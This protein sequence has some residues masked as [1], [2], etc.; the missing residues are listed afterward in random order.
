MARSIASWRRAV[1]L[2]WEKWRRADSWDRMVKYC[3]EKVEIYFGRKFGVLM[4]FIFSP[5]FTF[6]KL[7]LAYFYNF[8]L[9][10]SDS[11]FDLHET[12]RF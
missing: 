8:K 1:S 3:D 4:F 9:T 5:F 11:N 10:H 2:H 6:S 7:I 12:S